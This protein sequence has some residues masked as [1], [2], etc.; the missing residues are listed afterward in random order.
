[1]LL[2]GLIAYLL[3]T[4]RWAVAFKVAAIALLGIAYLAAVAAFAK[5][6]GPVLPMVSPLLAIMFSTAGAMG[7][8][9]VR[10]H[11]ERRFIRNA[12]SHYLAPQLVEELVSNPDMLRLGGERREMSILF[13]DIAGFT[14]MS[15]ALKP[16]ELSELLNE[17]LEGVSD[18]VMNHH[19]VIDKFIGDA[20]VGLFG[21][22]GAEPGHAAQALEC[23]M[24][25]DKFAEAFRKTRSS[26]GLGETRIGVHTGIATV[27]NF[28]G[29]SRFDYTAIGDAMNTTARLESSNRA[30]GTRIA[31][32]GDC[33]VAAEPYLQSPLP[34]Q[35]IGDVVLKG[36]QETI[37]VA[38]IRRDISAEW[39][40][41]YRQAFDALEKQP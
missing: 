39:L 22:P 16:E 20:V 36:K 35:P 5:A 3:A 38:T 14:G 25:I 18:I 26:M 4:T 34:L 19:G 31:V 10:A 30:F 2:V 17:Y 9:A 13:T 11:R 37:F 40:T 32:S 29:R 23:A 28:G 12:F 33:L 24:A 6:G 21:V 41:Q 1:V 7:T 15:E 27:G 8:D